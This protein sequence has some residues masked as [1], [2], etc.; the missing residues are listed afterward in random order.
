MKRTLKYVVAGLMLVNVAT[1]AQTNVPPQKTPSPAPS[2]QLEVRL[3][4]TDLYKALVQDVTQ[5]VDKRV[6]E[7]DGSKWKLIG[8]IA[9]GVLALVG[10][11]GLRSM[12]DL[13]KKVAVD[14]TEELRRHDTLKS[15]VE[16]AVRAHVTADID[17]R[18]QTV[19]KE[20]AFYRLSNIAASIGAGSGF[21]RTERD[22]A[23]ASLRELASEDAI[24]GRKEFADVLEKI[25]DSFAS[26]DLDFELDAIADL[27]DSVI[28][29]TPGIVQTLAMHYGM[30]VLGDVEV[31]AGTVSRFKK[32]AD[33]CR[34]H[35]MYELALPYLMVLEHNGKATGWPDG[36]QSLIQDA[37]HLKK[38][39]QD[40]VVKIVDRNSD[41]TEVAKR[42]T[43]QVLRFCAKF[44]AFCDDYGEQLKNEPNKAIDSDEE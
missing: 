31:E 5:E 13:R 28:M 41:P 32:Y 42:S 8:L 6:S 27:L 1:Y 33:A 39:E 12:A 34:R 44:K 3:S 22:A 14:V 40:A 24:I 21:T 17:S 29:D 4:G 26:A 30:R 37:T 43:G 10:F 18:L 7:R 20:L 25:I 35:N 38:E 16:E 11:L 23:V 2:P 15:L 9:S 19:S 36:I